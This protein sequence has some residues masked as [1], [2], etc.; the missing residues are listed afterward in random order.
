[1]AR[2]SAAVLLLRKESI[3]N[4]PFGKPPYKVYRFQATAATYELVPPLEASSFRALR[5]VWEALVCVL[6]GTSSREK[7]RSEG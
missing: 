7:C 6:D 3:A 1:M 2:T 5:E 4:L